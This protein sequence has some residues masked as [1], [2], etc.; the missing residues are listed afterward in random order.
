MTIGM[1]MVSKIAKRKERLARR[2]AHLETFFSSTSVLGSENIRQYNALYKTLKK[3]MPM[4]SLMDRVR[5]KQLTDSIWLVQR[6][7]R[8]QAGAIEGAQVEALIKL[9]MPKFGNFLDDDKRNQIAIDYFSGAEDVQ[10]KATRVAEKLGITRDMIEAFALELQSP[11]VMALDKMRAR[12]EHSIDQAEKKLTGPTCKKR[13][14]A[15]H[16]QTIVDEEDAKFETRTS[17]TKD[18][19]N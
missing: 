18:S 10:R 8:L 1:G 4:S 19:W 5:V 12:C 16:D 7:L 11:T 2:A 14:K 6:T 15:P 13:N 3:E 17:H 9:L